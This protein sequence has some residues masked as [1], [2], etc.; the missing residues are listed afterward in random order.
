MAHLN[1]APRRALAAL[2]QRHFPR[3]FVG[4]RFFEQMALTYSASHMVVNL[5]VRNDL[6]MRVFEALACG[7][8]LLTDELSSPSI[9]KLFTPGEHLV[10]YRNIDELVNIATHFLEHEQERRRIADAGRALVLAGHTYVHR[11]RAMLAALPR[12][13][14]G[15]AKAEPP[16]SQP[17]VA[18]AS[19]P[20]TSIVI[21]VR[22][23]LS[24]TRQCLESV[25]A[26]CI[27]PYELIVV[28][29]ASTDGT[30]DYL[31]SCADVRLI[32][33]SENR[34]YPAA[35][36][37]GLQAS[38]GD[39]IL[40]LNNDTIMTRGAHER[41]VTAMESHPLIG[42]VGPCSN[43]V[44]GQQRIESAYQISELESFAAELAA[45]RAGQTSDA[46][47]LAGFCILLRRELVDRIGLFDEAFGIGTYDD[48]DYCLR[49]AMAGYRL[50]IVFDAFVHHF[51]SVTLQAEEINVEALL[52]TN[53]AK[54]SQKWQLN[55]QVD[56]VHP[57]ESHAL[58]SIIVIT[59]NQAEYTR[60]CLESIAAHT[61]EPHEIIVVDNNSTDDTRAYLKSLSQ[62][63]V[64][65]NE[66]N[67]GFPAAVNQG[68]RASKGRHILLLNNDVIVTP[69]WLGRLLN[70]LQRD[71]A[72]G[73]VGPVTNCASGPQQVPVD[74]SD[75]AGLHDFARRCI[76]KYSGQTVPCQRLVG[77]C[78]LLRRDLINQI[79]LLD[80]RFG[81]GNF[82]DDDYCR[83]ALVAGF[84]AAIA[85]DCFIHHFGSVT[86][87]NADIDYAALL[88][89]NRRLFNDK[90]VSAKA[91]TSVETMRIPAEDNRS[92]NNI[93]LSLC[94]IVRDASRTLRPCLESIKPWVDEIV[95]IDTG[96]VDNTIEIAEQFG[97]RIGHF[98]W[99]DDFAAARNESIKL[100][101]G[102]WILWMDADDTIN[103]INGQKLRDL[104]KQDHAAAIM[105]FIMQV[106]CPTDSHAGSYATATVVD[107]VKIIRNRMEIQFS[108]RIHEQVLPAIRRL[109]GEVA[110]TDIY[111]THSG[112]DITSEG[113]A[114]KH[115]R[116]LRILKLELS[117]EPD[118]TFTLFNIGMTLLDANRPEEALN[119]L[120][121]SLQLAISGE[122]HLRKLYALI[123]QAYTELG[124]R[125]TALGSCVQGLRVCP[126][127]PELLFRKGTLEQSLGDLAAAEQSYRL[128]A[129]SPHDR[130]FS[131]V[132]RGILGI[133]CWHN[134]AILYHQRADHAAAAE[135][136]RR[137]LEFD[138][139]NRIAWRGLMDALASSAD[140]VGLQRL[141]EELRDSGLS[142]D[143]ATI[144][145]ARLLELRG[146]PREALEQLKCAMTAGDSTEVLHELCALTFTH[147]FHDEAEPWLEELAHRFPEDPAAHHNLATL[148]FRKRQHHKAVKSAQRSLEL[149]P[150][151][152]DTQRILNMALAQCPA[153]NLD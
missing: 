106:H 19:K 137:V 108:G 109:G 117:D 99:R 12:S 38:C 88:E 14:K 91:L 10:T 90:W 74:Y 120:C 68:I 53:Q 34:G 43:N 48:Y 42:L 102:Q 89:R 5:S 72:I 134:L 93:L 20:L 125:S 59:H 129:Q 65:E 97:A 40:L 15:H 54:F 41:M 94:M 18:R 87:R 1:T 101:S 8:L 85:L 11:M 4:Q 75:F 105:G 136:W 47:V 13:L 141:C 121:R 71:P 131:S 27:S 50:V 118:S 52:K 124:R 57:R 114:R 128:L 3:S 138:R 111:V 61:P 45:R 144:G 35:V 32:E 55:P 96:S 110:W 78:L 25:R 107:H 29:N 83:R 23:Q 76:Q 135:A 44:P 139:Q 64:I 22:N 39:R 77:F 115:D 24:F 80:E 151:H 146:Q 103:P 31:R 116:D 130:H 140:C 149:R 112:S 132:D 95:V 150:N 62:V 7:S 63:H 16:R 33:N 67:L 100:A 84:R 58:T 119:F 17:S 147:Q 30:R 86:F 122:S 9:R 51:G 73:L 46:R 2:I 148:Y 113:R 6:N 127:D 133:K 69:D 21:P 92:Q 82:E 104:L 49:T 81:I 98:A 142:T 60:Q 28:D 56:S 145:Q 143:M 36:N 126:G 123:V 79:G 70:V 153:S 37:L 26:H 152:P 66:T